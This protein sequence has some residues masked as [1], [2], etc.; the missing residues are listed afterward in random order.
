MAWALLRL[1]DFRL[2]RVRED[3]RI[4]FGLFTRV[5]ATIPIR[6]VQTITIRQGPLHQWLGRASVRVETAGGGAGAKVGRAR[7][8]ASGWR[9]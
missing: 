2:T 8:I 4:E 5:T 3:L 9:R 1:Y 6:R 7:A